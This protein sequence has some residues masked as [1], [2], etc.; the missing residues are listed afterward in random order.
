LNREFASLDEFA[1]FMLRAVAAVA[2]ADVAGRSAAAAFLTDKA[3]DRIG[4]A[5]LLPPPLAEA[6]QEERVKAGFSA[7]ETLL[8]SGALRDS[9]GWQHESPRK[10]VI[11]STDE[12][13][14]FHELGTSRGIPARSF[15]ASTANEHGDEAVLGLYVQA[16]QL[17]F[18]TVR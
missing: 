8:R 18:R 11:G 4:K 14:V 3:K 16:L 2:V 12:K 15:L 5:E 6:T 9:I 10:T 7:D 13:A 17:A 1:A